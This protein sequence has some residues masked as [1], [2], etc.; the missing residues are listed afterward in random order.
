M[1][2][3]KPI[4]CFATQRA[5]QHATGVRATVS[6]LAHCM[7]RPRARPL[8]AC[9]GGHQIHPLLRNALQ[10]CIPDRH[11]DLQ[12]EAFLCP[13]QSPIPSMQAQQ[14]SLADMEVLRTRAVS[15]LSDKSP[16]S[17]VIG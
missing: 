11:S 7:Y 3:H 16:K 15:N 1:N 17:R 4:H 13:A 6:P 14:Q 9:Q 8:L 12:T 5:T 2:V 10:I